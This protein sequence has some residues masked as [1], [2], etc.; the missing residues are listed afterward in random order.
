M[1]LKTEG[2]WVERAWRGQPW[3]V[4]PIVLMRSD[5]EA[6]LRRFASEW[7]AGEL[8]GEVL[9]DL[10]FPALRAA[11]A[12]NRRRR[13]LR[14]LGEVGGVF[15]A[16]DDEKASYRDLSDPAYAEELVRA[17]LEVNLDD[18]RALTD[19]I[20]RFGGLGSSGVSTGLWVVVQA[21]GTTLRAVVE[22]NSA[23][24]GSLTGTARILRDFRRHMEWLGRLKSKRASEAEWSTFVTSLEP[25]L[26]NIRPTIRWDPVVGPRPSWIV[27]NPA[28]VLWASLWDWATR[29]GRLRRCRRCDV[30]FPAEHPRREF[31]SRTCTNRASAA[32]WYRKKGRARRRAARRRR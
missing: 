7:L 18:P 28:E 4:T 24:R 2:G 14:Q 27:R 26:R 16:T 23:V 30:L 13:L 20:A 22:G 1:K 19:L 11:R 15:V 21:L 32:E 3:P 31:C 10:D 17:V 12:R 5:D 6:S 9:S 25:F 8:S 29:S